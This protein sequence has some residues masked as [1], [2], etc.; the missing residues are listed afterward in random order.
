MNLRT[1]IEQIKPEII[2]SDLKHYEVLDFLKSRNL[3]NKPVIFRV[4]GKRVATNF[5]SSR[6]ALARL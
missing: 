4:E 2:D 3:L 6:E 5:L 1:A